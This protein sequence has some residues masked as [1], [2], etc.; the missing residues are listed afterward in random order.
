MRDIQYYLY[1]LASIKFLISENF[2]YF[3]FPIWSYAKTMITDKQKHIQTTEMK[4]CTDQ[5][6][7]NPLLRQVWQIVFPFA[8][9]KKKKRKI[10]WSEENFHLRDNDTNDGHKVMTITH[11][12]FWYRWVLTVPEMKMWIYWSESNSLIYFHMYSSK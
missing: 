9:A 2:F 6:R 1:S 8:F 5:K 3:Y 7:G 12:D 10:C 11:M 4:A